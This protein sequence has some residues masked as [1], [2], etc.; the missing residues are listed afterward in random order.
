MSVI[1]SHLGAMGRTG[2]AM[3]QI[4]ATVAYGIKH[5]MPFM[6]PK[7]EGFKAFK[8]PFHTYNNNPQFPMFRENGFHYSEIPKIE[9]VDLFGYFQ[10]WKYFDHCEHF[11]RD[12]FEPND[13][14]KQNILKLDGD[15][16]AIHIRRGDYLRLKD[17]H[18]KL[19]KEYYLEAMMVVGAER[20]IIFSDD[21]SWCMD[22]F[23]GCEFVNTG[24]DIVDFYTMSQC[25]HFIL[26]NSSYSWWSSFLS[27]YKDGRIIAPKKWFAEKNAHAD[28]K[29]LYRPEMFLL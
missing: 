23:A 10:S 2:N 7:W 27:P 12:I 8:Y 24:D 21:I 22:N 3:F 29:D 17:Y 13:I 4:A 25:K 14:I 20:N 19:P 11:I 18:T 28:T 5:N 26:A 1:Y 9:N 6:F 15:T 16:C